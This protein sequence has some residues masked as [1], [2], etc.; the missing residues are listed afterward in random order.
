MVAKMFNGV[1]WR[2]LEKAPI[3]IQRRPSAKS[4]RVTVFLAPVR[5][6]F[7][8]LNSRPRRAKDGVSGSRRRP[9]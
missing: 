8:C 5:V 7:R 4:E 1:F 2:H 9:S 6:A 3:D